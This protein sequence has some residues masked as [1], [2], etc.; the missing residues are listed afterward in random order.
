[1][2]KKHPVKTLLDSEHVKE[3]EIKYCINRHGSIF[4]KFFDDSQTKSSPK[5]LF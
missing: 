3:S 5:I 4:V 1:M 2:A